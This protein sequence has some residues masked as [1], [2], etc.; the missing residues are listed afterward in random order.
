VIALQPSTGDVLAA[1][2]GPTGQ[3][4]PV[5]LVGQYA[6]GS[7]FKT[8]T[9]SAA[10][11]KGTVHPDD[12]VACP[13]STEV[14]GRVIPNDHDFDLGDVPMHTAF[15]QSCNTTQAMISRDL[16]PADLK[17]TAARL[18]LG[19]DFTAPGMTSVTG[20]VPETGQGAARVESAIGQGQV[21]ASPFGLALMEASVAN[22]GRMV[23]PSVIQG[24]KTTSDQHPD[25]LDP[26]VVEELRSMMRE[27]VTSG[28][29]RS[30]SDIPGLGGKTGTAEV[31]GGA[32]HGWFVGTVG[33]LAFCTFIAGA[34]SSEPAVDLSGRFLRDGALSQYTA[35]VAE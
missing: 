23:T 17:N 20:S 6:P 32:A 33:D 21:V 30:L 35:G 22:G 16:D 1:A 14:D 10:L 13:A 2:L 12:T 9:T 34:D 8:V 3:S 18:G 15:A 5:G 7:T 27:T 31:D 25:P 19:V 4:Y 26:T 11:G 24:Q 28:T 29:A